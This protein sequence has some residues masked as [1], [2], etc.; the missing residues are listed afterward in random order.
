MQRV[1]KKYPRRIE[2]VSSAIIENNSGEILLVQSP[3]WCN[4]WTLPGGHIQPG[5]TIIKSVLREVGEETGLKISPICIISW[6]ELINSSNFHRYAHF[7]YFDVYCKLSGG[8]LRLD[9]HEL[10]AFKWVLPKDA[11]Q[12][13][14]AESY[15]ETIQKYID[16]VMAS[17]ILI[18]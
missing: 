8:K 4:K 7:I 5:E 3:K 15:P 16:Y 11:L 18:P 10:T 6:G 9:K 14:L 13:D 2:V 1:S 12:L 17:A